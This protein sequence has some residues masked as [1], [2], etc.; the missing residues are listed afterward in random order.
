MPNFVLPPVPKYKNFNI[1]L[2]YNCNLRCVYC[3]EKDAHNNESNQ[4]KYN[5]KTLV[6]FLDNFRPYYITLYGGE[7]TVRPDLIYKVVENLSPE[8]V[9]LQTNGVRLDNLD[10]V[11]VKRK[12]DS[13]LLSIDGRP[14][15]QD[16][17][18]GKNTYKQI[19]RNMIWLLEEGYCGTAYARMAVSE[20]TT[21]LEKDVMHLV[22]SRW[23]K[24]DGVYWQI[25]A[26][27]DIPG[28]EWSDFYGWLH[29]CYLPGLDRLFNIWLKALSK[30][31]ILPIIPFNEII[32]L[33]LSDGKSKLHCGCGWRD[34]AIT[35]D[36][37]VLPCPVAGLSEFQLCNIRDPPPYHLED[38]CTVC[39]PCMQCEAS[40]I[41]GGRCL[42]ASHKNE[43]GSKAFSEVCFSTKHLIAKLREA[44]P[45]V[46]E[47]INEGKISWDIL[48][49]R[50]HHGCEVI[51]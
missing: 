21:E 37:V 25:N 51:P 14:K 30:G 45:Q 40:S 39:G 50:V 4:I 32:S 35:T 47:W 24:F 29:K 26:L 10:P 15:T 41:C 7:P 6:K 33:I 42:L 11:F 23:C 1:I 27:S 48:A 18:R 8:K 12:V 2:T 16:F 3:G 44:T 28:Y 9:I 31:K 22:N 36:G 20:Q 34:F 46:K 19:K 5:L 17:Y 49:R 43:W 13:I 38:V